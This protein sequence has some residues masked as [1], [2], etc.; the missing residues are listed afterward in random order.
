M[1][2]GARKP[3]GARASARKAA[4]S[5]KPAAKP[6]PAAQAKPKTRRATAAST[7]PPAAKTGVQPK[8][9][10]RAQPAKAPA[11][12]TKLSP[13]GAKF[14][15][16]FE[17]FRSRMY[18]DAAG[19][20]T[21]GYGHLVHHGPITGTEPEEFRRGITKERAVEL[22]QEDAAKAAAA[23]RKSVKV[24]LTQPQFDALVSFAFNV[25]T[26]AFR[27]STLLR[28]L[29]AG[30]YSAVQSELNRWVKANGRTLQGLVRRRGAEG[31][32]FAR[33]VY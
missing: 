18:N 26:E 13:E 22:L 5:A 2:N 20:C 19:H 4:A 30:G 11:R 28:K 6:K 33:G 3:T 25:G 8:R 17:G 10:A 29:N 32:L 27:Q 1:S 7:R 14:I 12:P 9:A 24:G 23:V 15:A 31:T 21:I 16:T